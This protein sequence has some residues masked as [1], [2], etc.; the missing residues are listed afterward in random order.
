MSGLFQEKF[1]GCVDLTNPDDNGLDIAIHVLEP[2][3]QQFTS[4]ELLGDI[5]AL[6]AL[7]G[8]QLAQS[9]D[10]P[11]DAR[12]DFDLQYNGRVGCERDDNN[13]MTSRRLECM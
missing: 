10:A 5:W 6:A 3:V 1:Y 8:A 4:T 11:R 12:I 7:T 2:I 13:S 9:M